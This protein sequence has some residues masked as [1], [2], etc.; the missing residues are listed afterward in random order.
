MRPEFTRRMSARR[1]ADEGGRMNRLALLPLDV[2]ADPVVIETEGEP[3]WRAWDA[4]QREL[5]HKTQDGRA[6]ALAE[7]VGVV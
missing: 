6:M 4:A 3:A 7:S 2:P 1:P 5:D